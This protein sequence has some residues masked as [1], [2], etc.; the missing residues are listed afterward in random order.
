MT[1]HC[2]P[3]AEAKQGHPVLP[4]VSDRLDLSLDA[5]VAEPARD[6][7][8]VQALEIGVG[9]QP[10]QLVTGHPTQVE[11]QTVLGGPVF[12][13]FDHREIGIREV[14]VLADDPDRH[15]LG[16]RKRL[17]DHRPP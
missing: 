5:P 13:G 1:A 9:E 6:H 11:A 15:R 17:V 4:G 7:D 8:P 16:R 10:G 12:E 2:R 3:E 14:D